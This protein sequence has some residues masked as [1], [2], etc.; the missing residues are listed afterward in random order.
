VQEFDL[1]GINFNETPKAS[2]PRRVEGVESGEG[3]PLPSRDEVWGEAGAPSPEIFS[4]I[5]CERMH[6][7]A[8][9]TYEYE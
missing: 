9:F 5:L 6:S 3:C 4:G 7:G 2:K 1:G 8:F